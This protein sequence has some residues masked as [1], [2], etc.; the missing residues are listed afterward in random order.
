MDRSNKREG[1]DMTYLKNVILKLLE[2]GTGSTR[3]SF[4]CWTMSILF[5]LGDENGQKG[6]G[7]WSNLPILPGEVEVLLPVVATL[8]QFSPE[9]VML[10]YPP[11]YYTIVAER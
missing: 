3:I 1:I 11:Y 10:F 5:G 7:H 4:F 6:T 9:E 2:T 8:L